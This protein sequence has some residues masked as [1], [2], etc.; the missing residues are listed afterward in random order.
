MSISKVFLAT[1][2]AA[3]LSFGVAHAGPD[4]LSSIVSGNS[5]LVSVWSGNVT[6]Q[7][8]AST[9]PTGNPDVTFKY[10]GP[11]DFINNNSQSQ[12]N[13]FGDFGF[14]SSNISYFSSPY[15][16]VNDFLAATMSKPGFAFNSYLS[17]T[18]SYTA[19]PGT[20]LTVGHDDGASLYVDGATAFESGGPESLTTNTVTLPSG[21]HSFNLVY[22]ESNGAPAD[23]TTSV[24]EPGSLALLGTGLIGLG[25]IM[26]RRNKV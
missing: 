18:G 6:D 12:S 23:L 21:T 25:L 3:A 26:R 10:T 22:V 5:Y 19:A 14:T 7:A 9:Q 13:T 11:I 15:G 4:T 8:L 1:C 2:A 20:T 17:F 16:N 24:P